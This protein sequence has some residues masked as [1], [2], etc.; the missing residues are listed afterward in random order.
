MSGRGRGFGRGSQGGHKGGGS[1]RTSNQK[2]NDNKSTNDKDEKVEFTPHCAGKKQGATHD[3]VKKKIMHDIGQKHKCGND[4]AESLETGNKCDDEDALFTKLGFKPTT[5]KDDNNPTQIELTECTEHAKEKNERFGSH[6]DNCEKAFSMTCGFC[7]K[8]TQ[9][10]L[11]KDGSHKSKM[12]GD[13]FKTLEAMKLKMC[14]PSKVKCPFVTLCEQME[15]SMTTKQDNDKGTVDCTKRF[16]QQQDN[17]ESIM[18]KKWLDTFIESTSDCANKMSATK[19]QDS[20][21]KGPARRYSG[22]RIR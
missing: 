5:F 9:P 2:H 4:P 17:A 10:R 18:G 12:K 20:K 7:D 14:D 13:P 11:E 19:K 22:G 1:G 3:T 16:K 15:R 21:D 6:Q 8:V